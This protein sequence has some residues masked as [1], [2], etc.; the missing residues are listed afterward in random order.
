MEAIRQLYIRIL[1]SNKSGIVTTLPK[2]DLVDFNN[3]IG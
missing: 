2:K 3:D 1:T